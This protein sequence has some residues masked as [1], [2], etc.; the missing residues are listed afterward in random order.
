MDT[1][2]LC[3]LCGAPFALEPGPYQLEPN[4][5]EYKWLYN[6]QLL[7]PGTAFRNHRMTSRCDND[8]V[9]HHNDGVVVSEA[10][11]WSITDA[12]FLL[13]DD[14]YYC[15]LEED[16]ARDIIFSLHEKCIQLADRAFEFQRSDQALVETRSTTSC[17]YDIL[18]NYYSAAKSNG[19]SMYPEA[20]Q[21]L[22]ICDLQRS[23][24]INLVENTGWWSGAY[25]LIYPF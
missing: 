2:V 9:P 19:F 5:I 8:P 23:D 16:E 3:V 11:S 18:K 4:R 6:V 7:G 1:T 20:L 22:T 10:M 14:S 12:N 25:E 13:L 24:P 21:S 17:L 15:V